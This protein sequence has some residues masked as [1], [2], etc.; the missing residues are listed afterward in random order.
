[1]NISL[2]IHDFSAMNQVPIGETNVICN[3]KGYSYE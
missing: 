3:P 2:A 1:M